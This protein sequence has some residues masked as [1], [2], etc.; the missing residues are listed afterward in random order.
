MTEG[1]TALRARWC[2]KVRPT[3]CVWLMFTCALV[4]AAPAH[5]PLPLGMAVSV[6]VAKSACFADT[7]Q[8]I[9][10]IVPRKEVFVR[11]DSE[12]AQLSAISAEPGDTVKSGQVLA[13]LSQPSNKQNPS[14]DIDAPAAGLV[15][16]GPSVLGEKVSPRGDPLFR[17]AV[18]GDLDLS[19]EA[20]GEGCVATCDGPKC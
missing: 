19:A 3:M 9:G 20:S 18:G 11:P 8:L 6:A 17:I 2:G 13:K 12:G 16:T 15:L 1:K 4:H 5:Q 7:V 14:V 10:S